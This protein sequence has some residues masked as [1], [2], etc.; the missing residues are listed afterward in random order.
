MV[1]ALSMLTRLH[2]LDL[3]FESPQSRPDWAG[4]RPPPPTRSVLPVLTRFVFKGV[5]DYLEDLVAHIDAPQLNRLEVTLFNQI[6]FD[7]IHPIYQS[8]AKLGNIRK[9]RHCFS[10]WR[11]YHQA[12]IRDIWPWISQCENPMHRVGLASFVY[13]TDLHLV[14]ASHF[15]IG[16][17]LH[18]RV[19]IF[20]TEWGR[21]RREHIMVGTITSIYLCEEP[22]PV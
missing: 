22:L 9:C 10:A 20:A 8:G 1:T 4:R 13:G 21:Q 7:T 15:H 11:R 5:C 14:L 6:V 2:R 12:L 16:E 19:A 18:L 3:S 17:S